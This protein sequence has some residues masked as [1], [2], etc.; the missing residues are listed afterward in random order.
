MQKSFALSI[1]GGA[2][3]LAAL[4]LVPAQADDAMTGR[5]VM[6][7]WE[8]KNRAKDETTKAAMHIYEGK[9]LA[10]KRE[11]TTW[12]K[13]GKSYEDRSLIRF[14][15]PADIRGTGMLTHQHGKSEDDQWIYLP[16]TKKSKRLASG[17]R[18]NS[19]VGSDYSYEDL[20]TEN[21]SI[22]SYKVVEKSMIKKLGQECYV[23]DAMPASE[24]EKRNSG[25]SKRRMWVG[26]KD[27]QI[28]RIDYYKADGDKGV[29]KSQRF[30]DFKSLPAWKGFTRAGK[31]VMLNKKKKSKTEFVFSDRTIDAGLG[32]D[33][34]SERKLKE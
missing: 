13:T 25:Y 5:Q 7:S 3:A 6:E 11:L 27:W 16:A 18:K 34:F 4:A 24:A 17:E 14:H 15:A 33:N 1:G 22:Y 8:K 31:A 30:S 28:H 2:L 21:L 9:A 23:V 26:S 10:K 29:I 19:F 12:V 20:R 32:D